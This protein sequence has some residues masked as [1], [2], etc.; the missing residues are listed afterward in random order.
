LLNIPADQ[1]NAM[2]NAIRA[3]FLQTFH[4]F[5]RW[6]MLKKYKDQLN[7]M[8]DRHP[9]LKDKLISVINHLLNLEQFE[10]EWATMCDEFV[11]HDRVTIHTLYNDQ[12][13]WIAAYFKEGFCRTIP[14][15]QRS[16]SVNSMVKGG[17]LYNSMSVH[18]FVKHFLDA[19][20]HIHD[21]EA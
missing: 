13:M 4:R 8:Y 10:A 2:E 15:I 3:L 20:V 16:E 5:Y 14:S 6:H 12:H 7:Q 19:L 18:E 9:K 21:N 11:L 1:D 17:Y